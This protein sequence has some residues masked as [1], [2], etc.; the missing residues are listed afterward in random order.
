MGTGECRECIKGVWI[1]KWHMSLC[2]YTR[3][4]VTVPSETSLM[5]KE[6]WFQGHTVHRPLQS[7]GLST[8]PQTV[9]FLS[10]QLHASAVSEFGAH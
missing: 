3:I 4:Y 5:K 7:I 9:L 2:K 1:I 10:Q 8:G 6:K